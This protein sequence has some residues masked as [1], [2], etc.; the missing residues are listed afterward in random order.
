[1]KMPLYYMLRMYVWCALRVYF[2]KIIVNGSSHIPSKGAV[3][4][5]ANHQNALLDALV[6]AVTAPRY[7]HFIARADAFRNGLVARLLSLINMKPVYRMRDGI[8]SISNNRGTF[9]W[10]RNLLLRNECLLF[11]PEGNHSLLRRVRPLSKGF[12]RIIDETLKNN[13]SVGLQVV[14]IGI[15]Y[16]DHTG[17]RGS[18]SIYYGQPVDVLRFK[19][20]L[21]ALRDLMEERIKQLTNHVEDETTYHEVIS[22]LE[23]SDP[24]YLDPV[25]TNR[26]IK[27]IEA[28][29]QLSVPAHNRKSANSLL[30]LLLYPVYALCGL[31][32]ALPLICWR[33]VL[34]KIRD[35]VF[36][37]TFRFAIG[38][39]LVPMWYAGIVV[40]T[41]HFLHVLAALVVL[42]LCLVSLPLRHA[43]SH[44]TAR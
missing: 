9:T 12:T 19:D 40:L 1:M 13:P 39:T 32:N 20:N 37:G 2:T 34:K 44:H 18:V 36:I 31:V 26:R 17:F 33:L 22:K 3:L 43:L 25:E 21:P 42:L 6:F 24:N 27:L 41:G 23:E 29:E 30:R 5:L 8:T 7:S 14:P 16:T 38:I 4:F 10:A 35:P 28:G 11:F 15:N